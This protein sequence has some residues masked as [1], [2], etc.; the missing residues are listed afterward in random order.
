MHLKR[1]YFHALQQPCDK[2]GV[3]LLSMVEFQVRIQIPLFFVAGTV[4][5]VQILR[6]LPT[7]FV[8]WAKNN[9]NFMQTYNT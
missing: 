5:L 3:Q 1:M 8:I 9:L 6:I 7:L 4:D 2:L